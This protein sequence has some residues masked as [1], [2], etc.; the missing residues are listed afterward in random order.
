MITL[1]D[2]IDFSKILAIYCQLYNILLIVV[3][4]DCVVDHVEQ[5]WSSVSVWVLV[6]LVI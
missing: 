4:L 3:G 5:V 6:T 1:K 2:I